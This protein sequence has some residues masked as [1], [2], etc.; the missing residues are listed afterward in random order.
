MPEDNTPKPTI[1]QSILD[2]EPA[3][4]ELLALL[5]ALP[6]FDPAK[7]ASALQGDLPEVREAERL[8]HSFNHRYQSQKYV[9]DETGA[10]KKIWV[11]QPLLIELFQ[12][13]DWVNFQR[14]LTHSTVGRERKKN[15]NKKHRSKQRQEDPE[16]W[17]NDLRKKRQD[18]LEQWER[19]NH[20]TLLR[21]LA[22]AEQVEPTYQVSANRIRFETLNALEARY[23]DVDRAMHE[24]RQLKLRVLLGLFTR[25]PSD[26]M[27]SKLLGLAR[28]LWGTDATHNLQ[29]EVAKRYPP[30]ATD[31]TILERAMD[32]G[33]QPGVLAVSGE[34]H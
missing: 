3:I 4:V 13:A 23:V 8:Y 6:R 30:I 32:A 11:R 25:D 27:E 20:P 18:R 17:F 5:A 33:D 7:K 14:L 29:L 16:A 9:Q 10:S 22:A 31:W 19:E 12:L 34:T 1:P 21:Q 2:R 28:D 24:Y 26:E 15:A